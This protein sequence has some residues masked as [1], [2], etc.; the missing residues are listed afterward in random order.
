MTSRITGILPAAITVFHENLSLNISGTINFYRSMLDKGCDGVVSMGT[1]GEANS[2]SFRERCSLID[3]VAGSGFAGRVIAGIGCCNLPETIELAVIAKDAGINGLLIMPP[4]F[5]RGVTDEGVFAAYAHV[6]EQMGPDPLPVYIYDF[7]KMSGIDIA[8]ETIANLREAFPGVI[9][10]IKNSSGNFEEMKAQ[11]AAF[12]DLDVFSGTEEYLLPALQAGLAGSISAGFNVF[13]DDA[14]ELMKVWKRPEAE[15]LQKKMT[16]KRHAMA[17][18]PLIP[19]SKS[20]L[21]D[22]SGEPQAVRPPLMM[23]K[24]EEL[25]ALKRSLGDLDVEA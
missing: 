1:T 21:A 8:M 25:E 4:F 6:I 20:L 12:E 16:A 2:L 17:A 13:A 15:A 22:T 11:G 5:Y 14:A 7:P 19:A 18:Y 9:A 23:L 10:G 24:P 3:A